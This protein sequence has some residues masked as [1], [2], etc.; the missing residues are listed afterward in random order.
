[1]AAALLQALAPHAGAAESPS[2]AAY[3]QG[4]YLTALKLAEEEAAKG[5]KEAY[6]LMGEI[7]SEGLGVAQ[8]YGK[9]AD[10]YAKAADLGDPNAQFSLGLMV[11]EG[12]GVK[13]DLRIAADLFEKAAA[14]GNPA[15]QYNLALVY[16]QG[17][18]RP[19]DEAKAAQWMEKAA[20]SG[21]A[22]AQ[23][24]LGA[25]YQFGRGVSPDKKKAAEWTGRA[26]DAGLADAQVE[27][28]IML[29][30]GQGV[31][32]D[33]RARR[34]ALPASAEQGNA[35]A[36]NRLARLYA[37]GVAVADP[38]QAAKW[39]L[40]ARGAG[41]SDFSLDIVLSKLTPRGARQGGGRGRELAGR[42]PERV[43]VACRSHLD[44]GSRVLKAPTFRSRLRRSMKINGNEIRPGNVIQHKGGLWVAVK[45]Q[46]VK[47]R[48]GT[49][50]RASRAQER[51]RRYQSSTS[52][53]APPDGRA[54][55]A[56]AKDYQF[57]FAEGDM[58]TFMDMDT[59]DQI[60]V[61]A[62]FLEERAA[63]LQDGT[64]VSIES[65]EG[66]PIGIS[67]P[68]QVTLAVVDAEPVVTGQTAA[69]SYKP[70]MLENGVASW[71]P[72]VGVAKSVVVD[73][74]ELTY[75]RR[76]D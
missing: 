38:V 55:E 3:A 53:S 21:N 11:A 32:V 51:D 62:D 23:Y 45:T 6:T 48:Q 66:R 8:D 64:K 17:K 70:A 4:R 30:K 59:Y 75:V 31:A 47:P 20:T 22:Q 57:L 9:A 19:A 46:H 74:N 27:Y 54:R 56:R 15:A 40:L 43:A 76:A 35:V 72:F 18:G 16:L 25:L 34:Q 5:S 26:A 71:C 44:T 7:Y 69:S 14:N 41:V 52:A 49:G 42:A 37:N 67:L 24:D 73:T 60:Q 58:L 36:Q 2:Y 50:L 10:A 39:H 13:K 1:M 33:E 68:D 63:F 65:H 61:P 29:F 28:G 12:L